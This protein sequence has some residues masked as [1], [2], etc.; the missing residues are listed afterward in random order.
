MFYRPVIKQDVRLPNLAIRKSDAR[1]AGI[2]G[3]VPFKVMI[4]PVL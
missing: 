4:E 1:H 2:F 3:D